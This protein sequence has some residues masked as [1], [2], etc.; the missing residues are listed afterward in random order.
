[1][2]KVKYV[3]GEDW[4]LEELEIFLCE[5]VGDGVDGRNVFGKSVV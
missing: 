1:M 2:K 4:Y 3:F 5:K